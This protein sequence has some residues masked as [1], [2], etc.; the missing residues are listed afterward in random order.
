MIAAEGAS[1]SS[2]RWIHVEGRGGGAG[3]SALGVERMRTVAL[4]LGLG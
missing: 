4:P 1:A 2:E 3:A